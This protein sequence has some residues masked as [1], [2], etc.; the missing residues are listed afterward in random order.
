SLVGGAAGIAAGLIGGV[1]LTAVSAA[2]T[3]PMADGPSLIDA[4]HVPPALTVRGEP[5]TLRYGLI[6][7]PRADDLPCDGSGTVYLRDGRAGAFRPYVLQRGDESLDGRYFLDVPPGLGDSPDGFSYYA[8]LRDDAT[9]ATITVPSGGADAPQLSL[10]LQDPVTVALRR[11]PFDSVR[12]P[13]APAANA[14][15]GSRPGEVG[16]AGSRD[17]GYS[18]PSSFDVERDG[19]VDLL[20]SVNRRV[21][22][23]SRGTRDDV[24]LTGDLELA[25]FA[26]EPEGGYD[27]LDEHGTLEH[28]GA[29]G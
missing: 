9:G 26:A 10:P 21:L 23:W 22:R 6:C 27:V 28:F 7:T 3:T 12:E 25:D 8:V 5:I 15:R 13:D 2:G 16:L 24:P 11:Y 20:D 4:T 17:L 18:G 1:V 14:A 29:D 19:S